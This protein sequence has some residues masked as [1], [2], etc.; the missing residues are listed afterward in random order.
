MMYY[1]IKLVDGSLFKY[2]P[3]SQPTNN[4]EIA[5]QIDNIIGYRWLP[6]DNLTTIN[7]S[8]IIS[9][10]ARFEEPS[11]PTIFIPKGSEQWNM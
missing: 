1:E 2:H 3:S 4:H 11:P 9:V 10:S 6:I 5:K 8:H 7:V